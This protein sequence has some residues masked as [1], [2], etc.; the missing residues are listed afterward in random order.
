MVRKSREAKENIPS[1]INKYK[2]LEVGLFGK[3]KKAPM[4]ESREP[5]GL[6]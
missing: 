2:G 4:A 6:G 5:Q 1:R 3:Q